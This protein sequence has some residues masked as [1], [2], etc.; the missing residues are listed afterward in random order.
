MNAHRSLLFALFLASSTAW[1]ASEIE[2]SFAQE[3]SI[4]PTLI[5]AFKKSRSAEK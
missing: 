2:L 4:P 3:S 1:S 5:D